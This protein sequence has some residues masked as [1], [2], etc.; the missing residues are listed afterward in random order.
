M[1]ADARLA[2][3]VHTAKRDLLG[4]IGFV[5]FLL[6]I[7]IG[8][9]PFAIRDQAAL[10]FGQG[11]GEG[12]SWRQIT[13]LAA[14]LLIAAAA[15]RANGARMVAAIPPVLTALLFWCLAT[16]LWAQAPDVTLRRAGLEVVIVLS[17]MLGVQTIGMDRAFQ[18]LRAVLAAVLVINWVSIPLIT[19]AIHLPGEGDPGIVGDWRG[20]YFHKNIAGSVSAITAILFFFE[21][22]KSKRLVPWAIALGALGFL[23]MTHSKTSLGL[24]PVA[25]LG[26]GLYPMLR[27][28]SLDRWIV[29]SIFGL[30]LCAAAIVLTVYFHPIMRFLTD[31]AE[32]TGRTAIWAGEIAFIRDHLLLGA[33][34]GTFADTGALSPLHN[35]VA[36]TW[37]QN[38]AHGHN[39]Y[40][41]LL[42]TIGGVG[43][44]LAMI[45][46]I[47]QP[48]MAFARI[49]EARK[50]APLFAIFVFMIFHNFV[51][52][53]YLEGDGPAWVVFV[54]MLA[55]LR[56]SAAPESK[57]APVVPG[58]AL[59]WLAP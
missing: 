20:L 36:A 57:R 50:Y 30:L 58:P 34:F 12:D 38:E 1:A 54:L 25:L 47:V 8:L 3:P 56:L 15:W 40:L 48:A 13:F 22:L 19:Q 37:I 41:Q 52:S 32:L 46:F 31:P 26:G 16:S 59:Q 27:R 35:Y 24:L 5:F 55:S 21:A 11:T 44:M 33:G 39:A 7:F 29:A 9:K 42:V 6:L 43:F 18:L 14:F 10:A 49:T 23:V 2:A 51:E 4:E 28:K 45:A 17:A 53:D